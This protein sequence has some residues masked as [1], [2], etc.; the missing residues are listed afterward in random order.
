MEI[1]DLTVNGQML[2]EGAPPA[3]PGRPRRTRRRVVAGIVIAVGALFLAE[4]IYVI[5]RAG[6]FYAIAPGTAPVVS[7][8]ASC[9]AGSGGSYSLPGGQPCVRIVLPASKTGT[10]SRSG[11]ILMVDVLVGK[12]TPQQYFLHQIGLLHRLEDGT[13]LVPNQ[14]ILG[15]APASQL[16]CN[17]TQQ[18]SDATQWAAVVALRRLG[19]TVG[20]HDL[21]AQVDDVGAGTAAAAAGV[22]CN[23]LIVSVGDKPVHTYQDLAAAIHAL[24]PGETTVVTVERVRNGKTVTVRLTARLKGTPA[25]PGQAADPNRPFLGVGTETRSTYT[26]PFPLDINVGEIGGP[27]AG[28]ALTL[29]VLDS[30]THGQLTAGHR[31]AATGTIDLQGNVGDVGGVAQKTVAVRDAG[32]QVFLVPVQE[33]ATAR[34]EAGSMKVYAV[35]NLAQALSYLEALGGHIPPAGS[36]QNKAA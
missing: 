30:L 1:E 25:E 15:N 12:A 16:G 28:L 21:G 23:D 24:R 14:E 5:V 36:G 13:V 35:S 22:Q 4:L 31:I 29:G 26:Y 19:Y 17:D 11:S 27:S 3:G 7:D 20:Q 32:A 34:S 9:R 10:S 2:Q 6:D 8:Q 33:L 18:M